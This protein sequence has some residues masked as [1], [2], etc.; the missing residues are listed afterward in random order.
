[1]SLIHTFQFTKC[2]NLGIL[3]YMLWYILYAVDICIST[4]NSITGLMMSA[5]ASSDWSGISQLA[6]P[7]QSADP[8]K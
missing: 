5:P 3:L 4:V 8:R 7:S 2:K 1:M 6:V